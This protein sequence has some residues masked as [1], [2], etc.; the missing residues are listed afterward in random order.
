MNTKTIRAI[1]SATNKDVDDLI[2]AILMK[3]RGEIVSYKP[4]DTVT[5]ESEVVIYP[6]EFLNSLSELKIGAPIIVMRNI[7]QPMLCNGTR[8]V[9]QLFQKI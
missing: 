6:T 3:I 2:F 9:F 1:L 8:L 5:K 4:I 7:I